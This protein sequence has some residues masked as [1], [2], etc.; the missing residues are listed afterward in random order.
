MGTGDEVFLNDKSIKVKDRISKTPIIP[1]NLL[2]NM[3]TCCFNSLWSCQNVQKRD[4]GK[5]LWIT[6]G[7]G[8]LDASFATQPHL[9][10]T[11]SRAYVPIA[12]P[13]HF[14]HL[15]PN[16]IVAVDT[17]LHQ[18]VVL[19]GENKT[20]THLFG[21]L[22]NIFTSS[23]PKSSLSWTNYL[24]WKEENTWNVQASPLEEAKIWLQKPQPQHFSRRGGQLCFLKRWHNSNCKQLLESCSM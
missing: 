2:T 20:L 23:W 10:C 9:V 22:N 24:W 21:K 19:S 12:Y 8:P 13:S 6:S 3:G 4:L 1:S 5:S 7:V 17:V 11:P 18:S 14:N 15:D 16:S